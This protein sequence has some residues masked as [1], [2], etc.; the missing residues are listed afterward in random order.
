MGWFASSPGG[1]GSRQSPGLNSE[2]R[3]G[4]TQDRPSSANHNLD[5]ERGKDVM[6]QVTGHPSSH[7]ANAHTQHGCAGASQPGQTLWR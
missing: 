7:Y 5:S 4:A 3:N 6:Q 2:P 1:G